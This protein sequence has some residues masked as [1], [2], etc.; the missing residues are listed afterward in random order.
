MNIKSTKMKM[1]IPGSWVILGIT[2][3]CFTLMLI[4]AP[5]EAMNA[6]PTTD[7]SCPCCQQCDHTTHPPVV[8]IGEELE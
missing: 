5:Y 6:R 3:P 2:F 8:E 4:F 1:K 7:A